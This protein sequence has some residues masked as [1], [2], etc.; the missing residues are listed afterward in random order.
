MIKGMKGRE[1]LCSKLLECSDIS[2]YVSYECSSMMFRP[3]VWNMLNGKRFL[4][5]FSRLYQLAY[6]GDLKLKINTYSQASD[7]IEYVLDFV[8]E[9]TALDVRE[10]LGRVLKFDMLTYD[11]DRHFNNLA[12]IKR[13]DNSY[14]GKHV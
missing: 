2:N 4:I 11:V 12:V 1:S 8:Y 9:Y 10:Y 14:Y 5:T 13:L 7:R 6:G 3:P